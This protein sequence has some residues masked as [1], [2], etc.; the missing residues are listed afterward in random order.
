MEFGAAGSNDTLNKTGHAL[1][2]EPHRVTYGVNSRHISDLSD[3][4][5]NYFVLMGGQ[6]GWLFSPSMTDQIPL[7]RSQRY[8]KVP[9]EIEKVRDT[10]PIHQQLLPQ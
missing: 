9:L 2:T 8:I 6:D 5:E 4:N 3:P 7:Y 10:F 1:S